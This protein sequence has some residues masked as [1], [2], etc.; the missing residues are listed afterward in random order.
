MSAKSSPQILP[1]TLQSGVGSR[2]LPACAT[3]S[4]L[5]DRALLLRLFSHHQ[6]ARGEPFPAFASR[7]DPL[8]ASGDKRRRS[9]SQTLA[10]LIRTSITDSEPVSFSSDAH[11]WSYGRSNSETTPKGFI[12]SYIKL[13]VGAAVPPLL[14]WFL[15]RVVHDSCDTEDP[16]T[17]VDNSSFVGMTRQQWGPATILAGSQISLRSSCSREG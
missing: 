8:L 14:V 5:G 11:N 13:C 17:L 3:F 16:D 10:G 4:A 15:G 6:R 12:S 9:K 7:R 2:C 1:V